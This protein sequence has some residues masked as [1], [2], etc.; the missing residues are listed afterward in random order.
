MKVLQNA[1]AALRERMSGQAG[2]LLTALDG[3]SGAGKSTL[4]ARLAEA[5]PSAVVVP[6]DDF[7]AAHIPAAEWDAHSPEWR[8]AQVIN[9]RRLRVEA[10]EPLLAGRPAQWYPFDFE[11]PRP[12]GTYP[13]RARPETRDPAQ[14]ILLEGAY[15]SRPELADLIGLA[16]LVEAPSAVRRA[17]LAAREEAAFIAEWHARW[18]VAEDYYFTHVRPASAFDLV[19]AP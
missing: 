2:P 6:S 16:V 3:R 8:A 11:R 13:F 4:A 14:V 19:V 18:D 10:L 1:L 12:D 5:L 15:S 7:Y 9:W 17:R